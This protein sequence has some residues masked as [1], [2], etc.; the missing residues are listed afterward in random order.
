[1]FRT[2]RK[3]K[4]KDDEISVNRTLDRKVNITILDLLD[5]LVHAENYVE[6]ICWDYML[7]FSIH[8][9][10]LAATINR[11]C[12]W[13]QK[14]YFVKLLTIAKYS[15]RNLPTEILRIA[16]FDYSRTAGVRL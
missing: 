1:M 14:F 2:V 5:H 4:A 13:H 16:F 11:T 8:F 15:L 9:G 3:K 10:I 7:I 6:I 12:T